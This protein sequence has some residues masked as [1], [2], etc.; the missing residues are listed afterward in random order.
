MFTKLT[1]SRSSATKPSVGSSELTSS[2]RQEEPPGKV[3]CTDPTTSAV[4]HQ[5]PSKHRETS[6]VDS[7]KECESG[8]GEVSSTNPT[9]S[10]VHHH[11]L[12]KH[13]K[14]SVVDS[15]KW[16]ESA[17]ASSTDPTTSVVHHHT[18]SKHS[19]SSVVDSGKECEADMTFDHETQVS[20]DEGNVAKIVAKS[21]DITEDLSKIKMEGNKDD[22]FKDDSHTEK[23]SYICKIEKSDSPPTKKLKTG[24]SDDVVE[25]NINDSAVQ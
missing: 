20:H 11:T 1:T 10:V 15:G 14:S 17:K 25:D 21:E 24:P 5:T 13:S 18:L 2:R 6:V 16:C 19:K 4:H 7:R 22:N 8:K 3:S 23:L 12:S 9:T